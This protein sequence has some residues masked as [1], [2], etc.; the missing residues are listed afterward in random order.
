ME[1]FEGVVLR[2]I[3][4]GGIFLVIILIL[5]YVIFIFMGFL[6]YF[7]GIGIIIVVGVVLDII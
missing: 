5:L 6:V 2:I 3:W 1:Y 7:G 4:G